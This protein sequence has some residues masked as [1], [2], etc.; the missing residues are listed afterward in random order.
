MANKKDK[1]I[2]LKSTESSE[3]YYTTKNKTQTPERI[4]LRKYDKSL[5]RHVIFKETK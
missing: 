5:R 2:K 1:K 4:E 3:F